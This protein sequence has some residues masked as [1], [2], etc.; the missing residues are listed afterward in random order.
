MAL[1]QL[2]LL[3]LSGLLLLTLLMPLSLQLKSDHVL[4]LSLSVRIEGVG[5]LLL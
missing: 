4:I 3:L 2:L 5:L 1:A